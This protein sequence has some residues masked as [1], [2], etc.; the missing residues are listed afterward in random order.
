MICL[1]EM[2]TKTAT[3][4]GLEADA[5][6]ALTGVSRAFAVPAREILS[7]N[8]GWRT[9]QPRFCLYTIMRNMG[10]TLGEIGYVT[11]RTHGAIHNGIARF[12]ERVAVE[13][14]LSKSVAELRGQGWTI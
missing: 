5:R 10:Y 3:P 11:Q 14:D 8:K 9:V 4:R 12:K 13:R 2:Q 7:K 1:G 6:D